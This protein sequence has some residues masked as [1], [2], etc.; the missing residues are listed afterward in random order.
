M[1]NRFQGVRYL[2]KIATS[3]L[4]EFVNYCQIFIEDYQK[5]TVLEEAFEDEEEADGENPLPFFGG[6]G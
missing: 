1:L 3:F 2:T 6:F 4:L 5:E